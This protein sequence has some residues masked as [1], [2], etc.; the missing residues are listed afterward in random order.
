MSK[1]NQARPQV[2]HHQQ[3]R[4]K[5]RQIIGELG[6]RNKKKKEVLH[7]YGVVVLILSSVPL[8]EKCK[9]IPEWA[10]AAL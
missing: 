4:R 7:T 6:K 2:I 1:T 10:G 9:L 8:K 3:R 5:N